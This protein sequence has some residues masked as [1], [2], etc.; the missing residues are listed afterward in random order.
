MTPP[1]DN[2][3]MSDEEFQ[4]TFGIPVQQPQMAQEP[5]QPI[6][7]R[8]PQWG[9]LEAVSKAGAA[10]MGAYEDAQEWCRGRGSSGM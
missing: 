5:A 4:N 6:P 7:Q 2:N 1:V 3:K 8:Q 9:P 10:A